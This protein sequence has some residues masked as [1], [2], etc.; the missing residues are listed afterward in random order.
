[1]K[2]INLITLYYTDVHGHHLPVN[3]R[4]YG[5]SE[6]KTKNDYFLDMV[7]VGA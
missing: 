5:K 1:V 6:G 2:G 4:V 7:E 3:F